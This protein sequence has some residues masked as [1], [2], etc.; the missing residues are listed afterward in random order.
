[1]SSALLSQLYPA[2]LATLQSRADAALARGGFDHLVI[3]AG[4]LHYPFLD[5]L[6]YPF[7]VNPHFKHW[8]PVTRAPGSWIVVTPGKRPMLIY[9]QPHDYWHVVP[10][11]PAGYWVEHFDIVIV[12]EAAQAAAH[13]PAR[14]DRCAILGEDGA[15]V[16]SY[17]PNNPQAV[18]DYLHYHRAWKTEYELAMMRVASH[19][20]VRAHRAAEAAFRCG[21]SEYAIHMAYLS[22]VRETE[23]ELP[24]GNIIGLNEHGAVLHYMH[25]ERN[26]P[27]VS[28]SL[29]IDAGAS[30]HGYACDI[31]RTYASQQAGEFQQ[32]V[33]AV[34]RAQ[35]EF[36]SQVRVGKSYPELHVQAHHV[37]AGI[38]R[39]QGFIRMSAES[40]VESGVSRAFF[41]HGLGHY[42]GLQVHDIGGFQASESGGVLPRPEGHPY[43]RLT[44]T[45]DAG[46]VM[47]IEPGIY[48]IDLL[49]AELKQ[50]PQASDIRWDKVESFRKYGGVRIEDDVV[51]TAGEPE[52]LTRDAFAAL[53]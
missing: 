10:E 26:P 30:F 8:L 49:L 31:T 18:T 43:L 32:L 22:A 13:L 16:G 35:Q 6:P 28:H 7:Q 42:I 27:L 51:C 53:N 38:L 52:N 17:R 4:Q 48:F 24:Y 9:L 2:H 5:D 37:L 39:E 44:R 40:A 3:A 46:Q 11:V 47:T 23:H 19:L 50:T 41:P 21:A 36:C 1:M 33:D 14:A 34:D 12:R 20:G 29:L 45:I 15:A 25:F